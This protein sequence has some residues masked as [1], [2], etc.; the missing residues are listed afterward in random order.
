M[1]FADQLQDRL[2]AERMAMDMR[3]QMAGM[4]WLIS[5]CDDKCDGSG[6]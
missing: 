5:K 3:I 6:A 2:Q 4:N 1:Q